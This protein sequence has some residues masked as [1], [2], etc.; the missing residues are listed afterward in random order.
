M[1]DQVD[2]VDPSAQPTTAGFLHSGWSHP[3]VS[4]CMQ[5]ACFNSC[6]YQDIEVKQFSVGTSQQ[7]IRLV[8]DILENFSPT[9]PYA[10]LM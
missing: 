2:N 5:R 1:S 6:D 7:C 8:L 4:S 3:Q 9:I 10:Q